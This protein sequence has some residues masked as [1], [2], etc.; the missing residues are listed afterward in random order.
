M[1]ITIKVNSPNLI[2]DVIE[3]LLEVHY[4]EMGKI[5]SGV[6][7]EE[8]TKGVSRR[9][10]SEINRHC[11]F[12][13]TA[14]R[15]RKNQGDYIESWI[16]KHPDLFS[17]P[18]YLVN[19]RAFTK[20]LG[21]LITN[22]QEEISIEVDSNEFDLMKNPLEKIESIREAYINTLVDYCY[23]YHKWS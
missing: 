13:W 7:Q 4:K 16:K 14:K 18:T 2:Q 10:E 9:F 11:W 15:N 12:E 23:K 1:N 3:N 17:K 5:Q 19:L 21:L 22:K 8:F 6:I 20:S